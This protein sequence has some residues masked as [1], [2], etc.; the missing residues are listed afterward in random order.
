MPDM[1]RTR[2]AYGL[3]GGVSTPN[4]FRKVIPR[5]TKQAGVKPGR[6][7]VYWLWMNS[8]CRHNRLFGSTNEGTFSFNPLLSRQTG[9]GSMAHEGKPTRC[10]TP[11]AGVEYIE[12]N[13]LYP[14][15]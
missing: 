7:A 9:A 11:D 2:A 15:P 4:G 14:V 3:V 12:A 1:E 5:V 10:P 8:L 13:G 6:S